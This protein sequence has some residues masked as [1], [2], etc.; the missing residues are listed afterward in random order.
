MPK[1]VRYT[2]NLSKLARNTLLSVVG[3]AGLAMAQQ[4]SAMQ[5]RFGNSTGSKE[6]VGSVT[7]DIDVGRPIVLAASDFV[8]GNLI[9]RSQNFTST[10]TC[11]DTDKYPQGKTPTFTG[12]RK[13]RSGRWISRCLL[14]CLL[15]ASTMIRSTCCKAAKHRPV[16][17]WGRVPNR[18]VTVG[19]PILRR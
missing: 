2:M 12:T 18:A 17:I 3:L 7:Q 9:W 1:T 19:K 5:C 14:G 6:P 4:A 8:A 10:F 13:T 16:Q 11:W 15:M